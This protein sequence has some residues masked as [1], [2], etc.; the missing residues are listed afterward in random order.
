MTAHDIYFAQACL[1]S[2]METML[3][4]SRE[5]CSLGLQSIHMPLHPCASMFAGVKLPEGPFKGSRAA[6]PG[7]VQINGQPVLCR[8]QPPH[9]EGRAGAASYRPFIVP[10][11]SKC[12]TKYISYMYYYRGDRA[13]VAFMLRP[14]F[15]CMDYSSTLMK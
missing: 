4:G 1:P 5:A 15:C 11:I 9:Q 10:H 14:V 2:W 7:W 3:T 13:T 8:H 6:P 12:H